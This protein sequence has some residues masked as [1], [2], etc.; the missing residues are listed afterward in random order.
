MSGASRRP[1]PAARMTTG[2]GDRFIFLPRL[3][4]AETHSPSRPHY[5]RLSG[6]WGQI[7]FRTRALRIA[8]TSFWENRSVPGTIRRVIRDRH[9]LAEERSLALHAEVAHR[10]LEDP[11]AIEAARARVERWLRDGSMHPEYARAWQ[12]I[13]SRPLTELVAFLAERGEQARALSGR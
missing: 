7:Y 4:H 8:P 10:L 1:R 2:N 3:D 12:E 13:L 11:R 9:E 6:K 5:N